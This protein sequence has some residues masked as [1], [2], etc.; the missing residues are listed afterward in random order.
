[1]NHFYHFIPGWFNYQKLYSHAVNYFPTNSHFVEIGS[2]KGC[3]SSYMAVEIIN[4]GKSIQFDCVDTWEGS[5]E[6]QAGQPF[7][8]PNVVAGNL[9]EVFESNMSL[10]AGHYRAIRLPSVEAANLY[11]D[12]SLDFVFIDGDHEYDSVRADVTAWLPKIKEGGVI[13]GH[14]FEYT[15]VNTAIKEIFNEFIIM[16]GCWIKE[17]HRDI[18]IIN[19][20]ENLELSKLIKKSLDDAILG[21]H[22]L[23]T[24]IIE[25]YGMSGRVY[26]LLINNLISLIPN[27]RYLEIGSHKGSTACS[28]L[29]G[30]KV[31]ATCI[32]NWSEFGSPKNE[33]LNNIAK[34]KTSDIDFSFIEEDFRK[35]DF[36]SIGK[37]NVYMFDGPHSE[38]DQYDGIVLAQPALDDLYI[39]IVDDWNNTESKN[40]TV[41]ALQ[42]LNHQVLYYI[43]ITGRNGEHGDWHRGY[44][45]AVISKT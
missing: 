3:S 6:H 41:R 20:D 1:M 25:M 18:I 37:Y 34:L 26:R 13:A 43:D 9:F 23:P 31:K 33:F 42:D 10:V 7:E 19:G 5:W 35:V 24:W 17:I 21:I 28:A 15:P 27:A 36:S 11:P 30:N 2:F 8:D 12:N 38:Q 4:S 14:D 16:D 32:D 29:Y 39:L 45:I 44:F 40:G 22:K